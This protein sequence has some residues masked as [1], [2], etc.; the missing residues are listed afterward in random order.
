M[1]IYSNRCKTFTQIY[2]W[3]KYNWHRVPRKH[4]SYMASLTAWPSVSLPPVFLAPETPAARLNEELTWVEWGNRPPFTSLFYG[5][6]Y[7][8][9]SFKISSGPYKSRAPSAGLWIG[10]MKPPDRINLGDKCQQR[11]LRIWYP[12]IVCVNVRF[13]KRAE[14][15]V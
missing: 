3:H 5:N 14:F 8:V 13:I 10:I 2:N 12:M 4:L 7:A 15:F 9:Q 6:W 1:C 11:P